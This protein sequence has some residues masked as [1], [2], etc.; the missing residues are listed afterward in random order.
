MVCVHTVPAQPLLALPVAVCVQ[1]RLQRHAC[2]SLP[3]ERGASLGSLPSLMH[4]V[5]CIRKEGIPCTGR[6]HNTDP[7]QDAICGCA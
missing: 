6:C 4:L 7:Q 5:I 3:R 2:V 1:V